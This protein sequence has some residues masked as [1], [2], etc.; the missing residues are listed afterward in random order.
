MKYEFTD[1]YQALGIPYPKCECNGQCEGTGFVPVTKDDTEEPF[2]TLWLEAEAKE[3]SDD[4][5]HFVKCPDCNGT[6]KRKITSEL[7][8]TTKSAAGYQH[9]I[10]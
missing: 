5:W 3:P 10:S 9:V 7:I 4:G 1:R 8:R 6:G 2:R